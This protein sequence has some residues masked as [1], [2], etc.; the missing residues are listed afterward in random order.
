MNRAL[1]SPLWTD[2]KSSTCICATTTSPCSFLAAIVEGQQPTGYFIVTIH[3]IMNPIDYA[4]GS[5][6]S[7]K[8]IRSYRNRSTFCVF[9]IVTSIFDLVAPERIIVLGSISKTNFVG[10]TA[11]PRLFL[12]SA[13]AGDEERLPPPNTIRDVSAAILT[14]GL[15]RGIPVKVWHVVE[16]PA[17]PSVDSMS[18]L[19]QVVAAIVPIDLPTVAGHAQHL[20]RVK[21]GQQTHQ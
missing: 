12:L 3:D 21:I 13:A 18:R 9:Q 10:E 17:G 14:I 16:D 7:T 11:V 15:A 6:P 19:G 1:F 20:A 2:I 5:E 8:F 4:N